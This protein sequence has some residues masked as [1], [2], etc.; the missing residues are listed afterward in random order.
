MSFHLAPRCIQGLLDLRYR[1]RVRGLAEVASRGRSGILF[2]PNHPALID[3]IL[4]MTLLTQYGFAPRPLADRRQVDRFLIR[5]LAKQAGVITMADPGSGERHVAGEVFGK[6]SQPAGRG[7]DDRPRQPRLLKEEVQARLEQLADLLKAGQNVLLYPAGRVYRRRTEDLGSNSAVETILQ[8]APQ[9]RVVLVRTRGLWG[10]SFGWASGREPDIGKVIRRGIGVVLRNGIFFTPKREVDIE[11]AEPGELPRQADRLTLNRFLEAFYNQ[12]APPNTFVPYFRGQGSPTIRPEPQAEQVRGDTSSVPSD[13]RE[14]VLARLGDLSG[15][16]VAEADRLDADLGLDS[17]S[18]MDMAVWLEKEFSLA[19][20]SAAG[21]ETVADLLLAAAGMASGSKTVQLQPP[22]PEWFEASA[23]DRLSLPDA[24]TIPEA[25]LRRAIREPKR[26]IVADQLSGARTYRDLLRGILLLQPSLARLEGEF[27]A[28]MMPA[29][30]A[31]DVAYLAVLFAGKTPVMINWTVGLSQLRPA[32]GALGARHLLTSRRLAD[33][34]RQEGLDLDDL[35]ASPVYLEDL[36]G[37]AGAIAKLRVLVQSA[38]PTRLVKARAQRLAVVLF[39]SGSEAL[40]KAVGLTHENILANIRDVTQRVHLRRDDCILAMLPPF[41]SFGLTV[42][43]VLPLCIGMRACCHPNPTEGAVLAGVIQNYRATLI[44]GTP[45]FLEGI[46]RWAKP[47]Q[48]ASLR[49]AVTGAEKCPPR[50]SEALAASATGVKVLEGYGVTECSPIISA[51]PEEHPI[52]G[53]IGHVLPSYEYCLVDPEADLRPGSP[54]PAIVKPGQDGLLLVR[55]PC[56]F[57]GY[58]QHAG[59][60]P[61]VDLGGRKWYVTGDVV[62]QDEQGALTFVARRKRFIKLGGEMISLPA[63]EAA[64]ERHWPPS[65]GE[66]GKPAQ[67]QVAV[68]ATEAERPEIVLFTP[69]ELTREDVNSRLAEAGLSPLHF[70]RRIV[71]V[72]FIPLLGTGKT[73]YR[74]LQATLKNP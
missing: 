24:A 63:V 8:L 11:F 19:R 37:K 62:R 21:L 59:P 5:R 6:R 65:P 17:L 51:T 67:P 46:V 57:G 12:D 52:R 25:F 47:G 48:L 23:G 15:R 68:A 49:V 1:I 16:E 28:V 20:A 64:L 45:T 31:A 55:G 40:P 71:R 56:V 66:S 74:A 73:D 13:V 61:F 41:H 50:V 9:A 32:M 58:L 53:T 7:A 2:L 44:V 42:G 38:F 27:L 39:T 72:E 10:S 30:V 14:R 43:A 3:P 54:E 60:Q 35:G 22:P 33:R 29:G 69:L 36:R 4:L 18:R 34:M 26:L 70:V